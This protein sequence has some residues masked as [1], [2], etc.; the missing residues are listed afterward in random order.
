M[1]KSNISPKISIYPLML[2]LMI[3]SFLSG[4]FYEVISCIC[5]V[6][7]VVYLVYCRL[8]TGNLIFYRDITLIWTIVLA[9][10]FGIGVLWAV[11]HGMSL[12]GFVKFLPL[13]LFT[14]AV[15][16]ITPQERQKLLDTVPLSGEIM[17]IISF[18]MSKI[19]VFSDFF[20]VNSRL[21]GFFQY[22]NAF[23]LFLLTGIIILIGK[24]CWNIWRLFCITVL[25]FG[26]AQ[27][28]SRTVFFILI[29]TVLN[30]CIVLKNNK[31]RW[32]L[33]CLLILMVA[34][35][36]V[37][38]VVTGNMA[39]V[40]RY[41]T[42]S[43]SSSTFL[44][45]LLYFKDS[46]PV[47]L[48]HPMGLGYM[49]YYFTQGSFQTGVYSVRNIHN[50]LLQIFLDAGWIP[51]GF[52][53][54]AVVKSLIS[55]KS[56]LTHRI[57]LLA[58]IAHCMFDFDLQFIVIDFVLILAMNPVAE[59]KCK[60]D[61]KYIIW[62]T[63][64]ILCI[65]S[66]WIGTASAFYNFGKY[67]IAVNLYP[68]Y[69]SAWIDML[70]QAETVNDMDSVADR[71]I[72]LNESVSLAYS[73]KARA[74]YANGDFENMIFYKK[75]AISLS[76]YEL[77]EYLDYFNMLY[78]GIQLYTVNS[79]MKS[80]EYCRQQLL[81]IPGLMAD[82]IDKT[83]DIAWRINDKPELILPDEYQEILKTFSD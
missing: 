49:G 8:K 82:V 48:R 31:N 64:G 79:D 77:E 76:K 83:D 23:A 46:I 75:K 66:L 9:I 20:L 56:T 25:L 39:D 41:L 45:R 4:G 16:Q 44:G 7:L 54:A 61:N 12:F 15:M 10:A 35:T 22:P 42:T 67:Q 53:I 63:G 40:G 19:P 34:V 72:A 18:C 68:G 1:S 32:I 71:V 29:I 81:E 47:I 74:A 24:N 27:S 78:V 70:Q 3:S 5:S 28:G 30:Y 80:A 65:I 73:A 62:I 57:L 6:C 69:T 33:L 43:L 36:T 59:C 2:L 52:F 14:A 11:D 55:K 37:Y 58:I 13:P 26:I 38:A 51:A 21:A 60:V 50:E 17:T